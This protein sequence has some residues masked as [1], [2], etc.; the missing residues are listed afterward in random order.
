LAIGL[1]DAVH[2]LLRYQ[3]TRRKGVNKKEAI[4]DSLNYNFVPTVL[5]TVTTA[6]GFL[7]LSI[8]DI[9]PIH[10]L[11][12]LSCLGT[13]TAWVFTY[14]FLMPI[15]VLLPEFKLRVEKERV[16]SKRSENYV[17]FIKRHAKVIVFVFLGINGVFLYYGLK[18]HVNADPMQYFDENVAIKRDYNFFIEKMDTEGGIDFVIDSHKKDG[19]K[20]PIFMRKVEALITWIKTQEYIV[21]V[22]SINDV[23]KK[24]NKTLNEGDEGYFRIP[25][26]RR[27]ISDILLL[28]TLGL[29]PGMDAKNMMSVDSQKMRV[30]LRWTLRQSSERNVAVREILKKA[31][32]IGIDVEHM[33]KSLIYFGVTDEVVVTYFRSIAMTFLFVSFII[34]VVFRDWKLAVLGMLPNIVPLIFGAGIMT[35]LGIHIDIG[36][37]IVCS[38]C[39][40]IAVDDTIHFITGF[41]KGIE[42]GLPI[43]E[44]LRDTF[45]N[46]GKA[47][48]YTTILL[49]FGFGSFMFGDFVPNQ[50]FGLLCSIM[51]SQALVTDL[52]FL[53]AI[54]M[55]YRKTTVMVK[56]VELS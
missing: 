7:S 39:L 50:H 34:F 43:E 8:T 36:T 1:A 31:G 32:N 25:E 45:D 2:L 22:N 9:L 10:D 37:A 38:V 56:S 28:Y 11:G 26:T 24:L 21:G 13:L 5:T 51:L 29:P 19:I 12:V 20:D 42:K 30:T 27:G 15:L 46:T 44:A 40:G 47:L 52:V 18:N 49:L 33:G 4:F 48:V 55:F 35:M 54:L 41:Q 6:V 17:A 16:E 23:V 14:F 3:Q 53:P